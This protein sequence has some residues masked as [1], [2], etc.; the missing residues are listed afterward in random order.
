MSMKDRLI[1][2]LFRLLWFCTVPCAVPLINPS[3]GGDMLI[4]RFEPVSKTSFPV[5]LSITVS[6]IKLPKFGFPSL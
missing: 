3:D 5:V 1:V 6:E 2:G 4:F